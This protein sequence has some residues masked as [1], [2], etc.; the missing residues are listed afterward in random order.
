M[1]K[2]ET[3][4]KELML[5]KQKFDYI[6]YIIQLLSSDTTCHDYLDVKDEVLSLITPHL[7]SLKSSIENS[8][9]LSQNG[10]NSSLGKDD[11]EILKSLAEKVKSKTNTE[12]KAGQDQNSPYSNEGDPPK[13]P[14]QKPASESPN[15]IQSK[16]NFA[17]DNRHL[18]NKLV[19]GINTQ[20]IEISGKAVGLDAPFIIVETDSGTIHKITRENII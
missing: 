2:I 4:I 15:S 11:L 10:T 7:N 20:G 18:A 16:M 12:N 17:L 3:Q 13:P 9:E 14:R 19:R 5:R 8:S 1:S 6:D